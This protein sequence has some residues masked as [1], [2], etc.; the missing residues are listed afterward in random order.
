[1][2]SSALLTDH[3]ELT[4]LDAALRAGVAERPVVFEVFARSLPQGRRFGVYAGLERL[5]DALERFRF[6]AEE[7]DWLAGR[8]FLSDETLAWLAR[9]RFSGNIHSYPEGEVYTGGS[10]LLT[11]CG[12]FGGTVLLETVVLSILNH[13][14]AVAAAASLISAAAGERPVIEMGSR[15]TDP[16]AAVAAARA[17]YVG[18]LASTSNLE[19]G[20]RY[21]VPT[22]G[23]AAH[24]FILLF[25]DEKG[26]FAAQVDALGP[27][28]TLLVDTFD[29]EAGIRGAVEVAGPTLGAVRIDSGT[30]P[31][32][33]RRARDQ[34]DRLG[35]GGTR[36]VV[37]GDLD[38]RSIAEMGS[39]PVDGFG[40]GTNVVLGNGFPTAGLIFKLA[41]VDGRPVRKLSP[42]KATFGGRKWAW[43]SATGDADVVS[44]DPASGPRDGRPLQA[45]VV[46]GGRIL[47]RDGVEVARRRH[48]ESVDALAGR[49][50]RL[51]RLDP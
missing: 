11:V 43:R 32:E 8:H 38:E 3:Y 44:T 31:D 30:L 7:L 19:A 42:G 15:R 12:S 35:A 27:D 13:D 10:P 6:G 16:D 50:L 20:R 18:G 49:T 45:T 29:T 23:T 1:V 26:A 25:D 37:T 41:E 24:A 4:M 33:A 51:D 5:L 9:Y 22:A 47:V 21:G 48:R 14:S 28:T 46:E 36:I 17:A 2:T 34:L 40:A 39:S